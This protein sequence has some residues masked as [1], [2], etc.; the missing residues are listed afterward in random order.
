[1]RMTKSQIES[2]TK[3]DDLYE[4]MA[5]MDAYMTDY[6]SACF[7]AAFAKMPVFI[8][9]DDIEKYERDRGSL[10]WNMTSDSLDK[11]TANQ[12]MFPGEDWVFPFSIAT[13]NDDLEHDVLHF[14]QLKYEAR[15]DEFF[16]KIG[17]VFDG[18]ASEKVAD[19]ILR[20]ME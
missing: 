20:R 16:G 2:L 17:L 15:L 6:S 7:E 13:N 9:A 18:K 3:A 8:Y 19:G 1:M 14:D 4:I 5:A 12:E 11:V 10:Y